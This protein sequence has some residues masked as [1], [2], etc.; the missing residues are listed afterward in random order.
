M[1]FGATNLF[2]WPGLIPTNVSVLRTSLF[3]LA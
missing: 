1:S 3:G 2:V